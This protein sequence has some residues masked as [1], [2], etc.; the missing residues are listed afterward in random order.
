M[1]MSVRGTIDRRRRI[2]GSEDN[3]GSASRRRKHA[4]GR[5]RVTGRRDQRGDRCDA[6]FQA[7]RVLIIYDQQ[8]QGRDVAPRSGARAP[9]ESDQPIAE[10]AGQEGNDGE[11][12]RTPPRIVVV[13]RA[14]G[15]EVLDQS[16]R[17]ADKPLEKRCPRK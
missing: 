7:K 2:F 10:D 12:Q 16:A 1:G 3:S 5:Q 8:Q 11:N 9:A 17:A 14:K 6:V 13:L 15:R 4:P